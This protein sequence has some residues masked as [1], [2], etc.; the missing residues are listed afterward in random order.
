MEDDDILPIAT[1]LSISVPHSSFCTSLPLKASKAPFGSSKRLLLQS[2]K[3]DN[4]LPVTFHVL[5]YE[6]QVLASSTQ[7]NEMTFDTIPANSNIPSPVSIAQETGTNGLPSSA[8]SF[9]QRSNQ[10][11]ETENNTDADGYKKRSTLSTIEK[12]QLEDME[13]DPVLQTF[14]GL[15]RIFEEPLNQI[16]E[17]PFYFENEEAAGHAIQKGFLN[18]WST[19]IIAEALLAGVAIQPFVS[20]APNMSVVAVFT[21]AAGVAIAK[22]FA[23][24]S[25]EIE[26]LP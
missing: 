20:N 12:E 3:C 4:P 16:K 22:S 14:K 10:S 23:K 1:T 25:K 11:T 15:S 24:V 5:A 19:F 21:V 8:N 18:L 9:S 7:L 17:W 2:V 13:R 26:A 6:F